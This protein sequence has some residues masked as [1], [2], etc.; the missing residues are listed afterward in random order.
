MGLFFL[1][2]DIKLTLPASRLTMYVIRQVLVINQGITRAD[3][4]LSPPV[5][6][7]YEVPIGSTL[8]QAASSGPLRLPRIAGP[9]MS[10]AVHV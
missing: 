8:S 3:S 7:K 5:Y 2:Y 9:P 1:P 4:L 6:R 10:A